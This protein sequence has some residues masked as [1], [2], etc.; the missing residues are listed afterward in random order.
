VRNRVDDIE[1]LN[2]LQSP[3][4]STGQTLRLPS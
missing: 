4:I 2:G 1:R 3:L